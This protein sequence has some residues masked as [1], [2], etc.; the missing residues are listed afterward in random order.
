LQDEPVYH[1]SQEGFR[2]LV[3]EGWV[4]RGKADIPPGR[5]EKERL[6]VLY[7]QTGA[8]GTSL[9]ISM[10][11]LPGSTPLDEYLSRPS[12]G[13]KKWERTLAPQQLS[14]GPKT[15]TRYLFG[16]QA[17]GKPFHREVMVFRRKERVYFFTILFSPADTRGR[18]QARTAIES[19]IWKD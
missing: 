17:A 18:D 6:L 10:A 15:A 14:L 16:T 3:P 11:D 2:L 1:N 4:V 12:F 7:R 13:V 19:I 8:Q 9:H 5:L